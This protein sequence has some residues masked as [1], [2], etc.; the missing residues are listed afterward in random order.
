MTG[1]SLL[2]QAGRCLSYVCLL[3][4]SIRRHSA[5]FSREFGGLQPVGATESLSL[6]QFSRESNGGERFLSPCQHRFVN[7]RHA[8]ANPFTPMAYVRASM[9]H[10]RGTRV[11]LKNRVQTPCTSAFGHRGTLFCEKSY[12]CLYFRPKCVN[13]PKSLFY[14]KLFS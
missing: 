5:E 3:S 12:D 4:T 8:Q 14:Y 11:T 7:L 13:L 9:W 6:F 2:L 1:K 10:P